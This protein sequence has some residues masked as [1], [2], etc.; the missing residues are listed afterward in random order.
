MKLI[1]L[2]KLF[3]NCPINYALVKQRKGRYLKLHKPL[4]NNQLNCVM[5]NFV[6]TFKMQYSIES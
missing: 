1:L 2:S 3:K 4:E 5:Y 6:L